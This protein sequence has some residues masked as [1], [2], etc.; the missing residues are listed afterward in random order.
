VANRFRC[1]LCLGRRVHGDRRAPP[2]PPRAVKEL[3]QLRWLPRS[4]H[5]GRRRS[6]RRV[7]FVGS[8]RTVVAGAGGSRCAAAAHLLRR[9][10][11]CDRLCIDLRASSISIYNKS[12]FENNDRFVTSALPILMP[13]DRRVL[14]QF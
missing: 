10:M 1:L 4:R 14:R 8:S 12:L 6:W 3:V 2:A 13:V 5:R 11:C 7:Q 9:K